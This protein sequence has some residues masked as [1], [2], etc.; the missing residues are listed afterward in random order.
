MEEKYG[1]VA[2]KIV[3]EN[4]QFQGQNYATTKLLVIVRIVRKLEKFMD[5]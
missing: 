1:F 5:A 2:A 4:I 3:R